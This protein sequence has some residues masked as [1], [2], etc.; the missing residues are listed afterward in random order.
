MFP[1][2]NTRNIVGKEGFINKINAAAELQSDHDWRNFLLETLNRFWHIGDK[3][4]TNHKKRFDHFF[5]IAVAA[6]GDLITKAEITALVGEAEQEKKTFLNHESFHSLLKYALDRIKKK[7][8][9]DLMAEELTQILSVIGNKITRQSL[10]DLAEAC[11]GS[12]HG[13]ALAPHHDAMVITQADC[14]EFRAC[15]SKITNETYYLN[16]IEHLYNQVRPQPTTDR[17]FA[18]FA[19][20]ADFAHHVQDGYKP[21][22][23]SKI[24][25]INVNQSYKEMTEALLHHIR[26]DMAPNAPNTSTEDRSE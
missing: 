9:I 17:R 21:S 19:C 7:R 5:A 26:E 8:S 24:F 2:V 14:V 12:G 3:P 15:V 6:Y 1:G 11:F 25:E 10:R 16:L 13:F 23:L 4:S 22:I 18:L 20:M